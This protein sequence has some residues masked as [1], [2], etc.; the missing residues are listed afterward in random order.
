LELLA[1]TETLFTEFCP[2]P[3]RL[4]NPENYSEEKR[5]LIEKANGLYVSAAAFSLAHEFGHVCLSH[6]NVDFRDLLRKARSNRA[7]LDEGE[8]ATLKQ[9]ENDADGYAVSHFLSGIEDEKER[10]VRLFGII[11]TYLC[12]LIGTRECAEL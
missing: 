11:I 1:Y 5:D 7:G 10:T 9:R 8:I 2:W 4:P 6:D 12:F 3:A